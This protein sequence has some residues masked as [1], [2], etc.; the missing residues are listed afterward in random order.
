MRIPRSGPRFVGFGLRRSFPLAARVCVI[1]LAGVVLGGCATNREPSY[2]QGPVMAAP[3][4]KSAHNQAAEV[5]EDGMPA[6]V[7][8]S[9]RRP[10]LPDDPSEP[11]S[12]NYGGPAEA[13][14][15]PGTPEPPPQR[16]NRRPRKEETADASAEPSP[17]PQARRQAATVRLSEAAADQMIE[18]A[19][20][21]HEMR[22]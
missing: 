12:P 19:I 22:H 1:G 15:A 18:R 20:A 10:P 13:K 14:P 11:W 7:A 6:Q 8:P 2:V 16:S 4:S 5:E 17:K 21:A 9:A 3:A